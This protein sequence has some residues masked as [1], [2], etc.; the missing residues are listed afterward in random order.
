MLIFSWIMYKTDSVDLKIVQLLGKDARQ[1]SE[2][3]AKKLNLSAA[4]VRRR[5]RKMINNDLVRIVGVVEPVNFG[6]P[7]LAVITL[8]I[9]QNKLET[10]LEEFAAQ[11]EVRFAST[12][13]GRYDLLLVGRFRSNEDFSDFVK[14]KLAKVKGIKN[15]ETFICLEVKK[16]MQA[17]LG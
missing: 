11:P 8:D 3:L 9:E 1:S 4:T 15:S 13:T 14:N 16:G 2:A 7:L 5:L 10:A 17:Q 6:F 12:I